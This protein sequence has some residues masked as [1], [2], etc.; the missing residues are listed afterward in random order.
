MKLNPK[1]P[2]SDKFQSRI[3]AQAIVYYQFNPK[4]VVAVLR[5]DLKC[6][7]PFFAKLMDEPAVRDEIEA[8][9]SRTERNATKFLKTLWDAIELYESYINDPTKGP[10][11]KHVTEVAQSAMRLLARGYVSEKSPRDPAQK[12]MVIEGLGEGLAN[13]TGETETKKVIQ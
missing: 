11:P 6:Y 9:M 1:I 13:L 12:P 5:P 2:I 3:A 8:I 10:P 7:R 4:S